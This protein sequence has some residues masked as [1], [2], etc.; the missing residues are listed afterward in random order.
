METRST[1]PRTRS[2]ARLHRTDTADRCR[3]CCDHDPRWGADR[4][5]SRTL[6][7]IQVLISLAVFWVVM[8]VIMDYVHARIPGEVRVAVARDG[9]L[10]QLEE[11]AHGVCILRV[12][13]TERSTLVAAREERCGIDREEVQ[14]IGRKLAQH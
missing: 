13:D 6:Q 12:I 3:E 7:I 11:H 4:M 9:Y 2:G 8:I 5:K 14:E 1:S 10:Y